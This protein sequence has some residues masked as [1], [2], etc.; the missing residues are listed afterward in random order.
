MRVF[1]PQPLASE[2]PARMPSPFARE[3]HALARR[4]AE[5][6]MRELVRDDTPGGGKMFGVLVCEAADGRIGW[7]RA[8]SGMLGGRWHVDGYVGPVFDLAARDAWWLPAER[9]LAVIDAQIAAVG[10]GEQLRAARERLAAVRGRHAA[11]ADEL[12][13]RHAQRRA[14]RSER[15][16]GGDAAALDQESRG[17]TA[18]KRWMRARH[19][20][21]LAAASEQAAGLEGEL[22]ALTESRAAHSRGYLARIHAGYV[23]PGG[24]TLASM[25]PDGPPPGGA[26]DC[27]A[28]KLIVEAA[29]RGLRPI[30]L[31]EL[32]WGAATDGR[33]AETFYPACRGKCGPILPVLLG[34]AVE[35]APVFGGGPIAADEPR[36]LHL[37]ERMI[38]VAKPVG[39][40]SVPG[41]SGALRDSVLT[42]LRARFGP[43]TTVVHRLDLDTSGVLLAAR[44]AETHAALQARFARREIGK[45]YVAW[46]EGDVTGGSGVISLPMRVDLEDRPRQI[47]DAV[48]GKA[49][50]TSWR[51]LRREGGRTRVELVPQTGRTHQLRVHCAQALAPIVGDAL[52]GKAG[53]RLM[54]H[55]DEI[56]VGELTISWPAPF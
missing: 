55:A 19:A 40:L 7:L 18:E 46:L 14:A 31:A 2:V 13:V 4:A 1:D 23:F 6:L 27:A 39:L 15:R 3:P 21:E 53:E 49:A 26:G 45:R 44:D 43:D 22:A 56:R 11:E 29:R 48:H 20:E 12:R 36:V 10:D 25:F 37:D 51:V 28:P 50:T 30:A 32:W 47:V 24:R 5:E 17:D 54:L 34:E 16:D 41:R 33:R 52:Y 9:E 35:D 38:V 8:F 42:R